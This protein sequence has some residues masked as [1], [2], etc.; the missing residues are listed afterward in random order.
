MNFRVKSITLFLMLL[1]LVMTA[2]GIP[3]KTPGAPTFLPA[4][5]PISGGEGQ[6]SDNPAT[7]APPTTSPN[8]P[9]SLPENRSSHAG[10]Y[11]SSE[12]KKGAPG[13]DRF[14]FGRYERPFNANTMDQYLAHLDIVDTTAYQDEKW[15]YGV[16][17]LKETDESGTLPGNYAFELDLN[18]DGHGDW[19]ILVKA[20]AST[21]W[22][23]TG[24]Q[25]WNDSDGDV[26]GLVAITADDSLAS[27]NGYDRLVADNGQGETP[28]A[29]FVRIDPNSPNTIHFALSFGLLGN[30]KSYMAGMWAGTG[31]LHPAQ[32]DFNDYMTH[33]QAGAADP[34]LSN[35]Y[36]IKGLAEL[37]NSCRMAIG[38]EPTGNEPG[39][40]PELNPKP[41][42]QPTPRPTVCRPAPGTCT[43]QY[44]YWD[45]KDCQCKGSIL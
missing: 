17:V 5:V 15:I 31:A 4:E 16:L 9:A 6:P 44:E 21:E 41:V 26:G 19:L 35:F 43:G 10:D 7:S 29:G 24:V 18:N 25:V 23:T 2:C 11:D 45:E 27:G 38:F 13:G 33:E 30:D 42:L 3:L 8:A 34:N 32:F 12:T 22:A 28:E 37:D 14:T 39:L 20:P 36:P 40:C 1:L